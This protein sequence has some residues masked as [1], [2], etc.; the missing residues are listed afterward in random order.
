MP[1]FLIKLPRFCGGG[2][3]VDLRLSLLQLAKFFVED[4]VGGYIVRPRQVAA[5]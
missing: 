2:L 3:S 1:D 4:D 5:I